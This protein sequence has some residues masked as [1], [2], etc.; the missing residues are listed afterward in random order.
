MRPDRQRHKT[1]EFTVR[2]GGFGKAV[3][4]AE[5]GEGEDGRGSPGGQDWTQHPQP[6]A[7]PCCSRVPG[8]G[9]AGPGG[10][11][12]LPLGGSG[13]RIRLRPAPLPRAAGGRLRTRRTSRAMDSAAP[14]EPGATEPL[15]R[16]RPRLV[17]RTQ[18]AHGSPTGRIE[19]FTNVRELYAKIAEA[20]GI[21]PTEVR[22][23]HGHCPGPRLH[24]TGKTRPWGWGSLIRRGPDPAVRSAIS[25]VGK[26]V[27]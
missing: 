15:T 1:R 21:A 8:E 7:S 12:H 9:A 3:R 4:R 11:F 5:K 19:G 17:F 2:A 18:L 10:R 16:A 13:S 6:G 23:D 24:A 27:A 25:L 22:A 20:F 14:R 26:A